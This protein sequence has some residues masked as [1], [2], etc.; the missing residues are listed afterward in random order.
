MFSKNIN[1]FH[2]NDHLKKFQKW[3]FPRP[4]RLDRIAN[5]L[6]SLV[7]LLKPESKNNDNKHSV[8]VLRISHTN[9]EAFLCN[10]SKV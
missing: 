6:F 8:T 3:D 7:E 4:N 2:V 1:I 5:I 9:S 10:C